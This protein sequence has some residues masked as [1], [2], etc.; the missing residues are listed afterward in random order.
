[1]AEKLV[2]G[3]FA[4]TKKQIQT[5]ATT[6]SEHFDVD[7]EGLNFRE[8]LAKHQAFFD[9]QSIITHSGGIVPVVKSQPHNLLVIAPPIPETTTKLLWRGWLMGRKLGQAET[10]VKKFR[11][12]SQYE[13]VR[14]PMTHFGRLPEI[15]QFNTLSHAHRL[16]II[17]VS[18]TVALMENDGI[19]G[20]NSTE[21]D[22]T[23]QQRPYRLVSIPGE[24]VDFTN[25]PV[26]LLGAISSAH[27]MQYIKQSQERSI[28]AQL[29][30]AH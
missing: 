30:F 1:M 2:I 22:S 13:A 3:G 23:D 12:T 27:S 9:D 28:P 29:I 19:F 8:A 14:H 4:S 20:Y 26:E 24:H 18:I 15:S 10:A 16:G 6:L 7:V 21:L 25:R 11:D 17:G 5:V